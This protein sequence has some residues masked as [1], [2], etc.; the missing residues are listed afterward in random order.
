MATI[1]LMISREIIDELH[2][3]EAKR[4]D[5]ADADESALRLPPRRGALAVERHAHLIQ[6][7]LILELGYELPDLDELLL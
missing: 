3:L 2:E 4:R 5:A 1:S 7:Y 6:L